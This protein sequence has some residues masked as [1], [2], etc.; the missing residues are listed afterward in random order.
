[1]TFHFETAGPCPSCQA[2]EIHQLAAEGSN[3]AAALRQKAHL[4]RR[5]AEEM[6]CEASA[7]ESSTSAANTSL[8][9][10]TVAGSVDLDRA[11]GAR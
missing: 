1:M 4:L 7:E 3:Y 8:E 9:N 11:T 6:E 2:H 10:V 5:K